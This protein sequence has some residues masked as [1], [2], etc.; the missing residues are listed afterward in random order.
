MNQ[1]WNIES[2]A[3]TTAQRWVLMALA[4]SA[5]DEGHCFPHIEYLARKTGIAYRTARQHLVMLE[6]GEWIRR[7][8]RVRGMRMGGYDYVINLRK[9]AEH[10]LE[11]A[12]PDWPKAAS[13][14]GRK[15]PVSTG[16]KQPVSE[17]PKAASH[18]TVNRTTSSEPPTTT[19]PPVE[20]KTNKFSGSCAKCEGLV[21]AGAGQLIGKKPAHL[22]GQCLGKKPRRPLSLFLTAEDVLS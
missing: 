10:R 1:V 21:E 22:E 6:D 14:T 19:S 5:D 9:L 7:C 2:E 8:R 13:G 11:T 4:D 16:R 18:R 17:W 3:M 15:Q 20:T 12:T